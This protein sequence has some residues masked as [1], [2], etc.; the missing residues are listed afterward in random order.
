MSVRR[1]KYR[2]RHGAE[3]EHWLVDVAF[4]H[5]DG[6]VER[7]RKVSPVQ[8]R[9]GAEQY[10]RDLRQSLLTG[11]R[12][13]EIKEVPTIARFADDF[14]ETYAKGNNKPSEVHTKERLLRGHIV[15]ALGRLRLDEITT[16]DIEEF[17]TAKLK[18]HSA[19]S[20][21]NHLA[22]L[23]RL[24]AV[25]QEWGV[26]DKA[27]RVKS[28]KAKEPDMRWLTDDEL[29]QLLAATEEPWRTVVLVA[30]RTGLRQGELRALRWVDVDLRGGKL[31]V[32]QSAWT[33]QLGT[34]KGGR[35]REV[36]LSDEAIAALEAHPRHLH[37]GL[38]FG[39]NDGQMRMEDA[40]QWAIHKAV[41][42]AK[43]GVLGWH[44]LRHT[45][46]SHL[47]I[48]GVSLLTVKDLLGHAD[49]RTTMRYA[50]LA[51]GASREAVTRL[52]LLPGGKLA[53]KQEAVA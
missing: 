25:A 35:S 41:D 1:Q 49:I 50:H 52:D 21:N 39:G 31:M 14:L 4:E 28:I 19:K 20:V 47:V 37:G 15:P 6:R 3:Q 10:E 29:A 45:F 51:P 5:S 46:A 38:V 27:P 16:R 22:V 44:T 42:A 53:A 2:D 24:F 32:R 48:R 7:I 9:R 43:L 30:A 17:K 36:P 18:T 12:Q 26:I 8:T 33:D 11:A 34:P 23:G 40:W 13:K